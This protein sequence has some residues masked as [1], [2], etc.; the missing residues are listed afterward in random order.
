[1][2]G[3][4]YRN[5]E[6]S[7]PQLRFIYI[8]YSCYLLSITCYVFVFR[9]GKFVLRDETI[10]GPML[11]ENGKYRPQKPTRWDESYPDG[12]PPWTDHKY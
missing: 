3:K 10:N 1:M 7:Y 4:N 5:S 9:G 11:D 12:P 8:D 6:I 2:K